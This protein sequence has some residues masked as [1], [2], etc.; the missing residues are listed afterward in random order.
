MAIALAKSWCLDPN[1]R[2][3]TQHASRPA[4]QHG[5]QVLRLDA[6]NPFPYP[7]VYSYFGSSRRRALGERA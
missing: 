6:P 4:E 2:G 3:L 1:P 7:V 5:H